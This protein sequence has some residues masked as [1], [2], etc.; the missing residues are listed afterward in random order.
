MDIQIINYITLIAFF[1]VI[2]FFAVISLM[3]IYVFVKY[4]RTRSITV[5]VSTIFAAL[6]VISVLTTFVTIQNIF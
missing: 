3:T 5:T 4:G 1:A 6:F 2:G